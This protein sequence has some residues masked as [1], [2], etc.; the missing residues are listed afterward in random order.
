MTHWVEVDLSVSVTHLDRL[1]IWRPQDII[2]NE[3]FL[4]S[5]VPHL[6]PLLWFVQ[7]LRVDRTEKPGR[8]LKQRRRKQKKSCWLI[9]ILASTISPFLTV[10][11]LSFLERK[12]AVTLMGFGCDSLKLKNTSQG[13]KNL[14]GSK[15]SQL[16]ELYFMCLC[17]PWFSGGLLWSRLGWSLRR[18]NTRP[19]YVCSSFCS[20]YYL[21]I[22]TRECFDTEVYLVACRWRTLPSAHSFS[23]CRW[24]TLLPAHSFSGCRWRT[25][26]SAHS[27]SGCRWWILPSAHSFSGCRWFRCCRHFRGLPAIRE[28]QSVRRDVLVVFGPLGAG[29][30]AKI[31][32]DIIIHRYAAAN[33][34]GKSINATV[35]CNVQILSKPLGKC[36][37]SRINSWY[38]K[39]HQQH[40]SGAAGLVEDRLIYIQLVVLSYGFKINIEGCEM[41]KSNRK[42]YSPQMYIHCI[43]SVS[44][45]FFTV[46]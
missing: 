40:L 27:F 4:P 38:L 34:W 15:P 35:E 13:I 45:I 12:S 46:K 20:A 21:S 16:T 9:L 36:I 1:L 43:G 10:S 11:S 6:P 3:A 23:G 22:W 33:Q 25:L 31:T 39:W 18:K 26:P 30:V 37:I 8:W 24:R 28:L 17:I 32:A 29:N 5:V 42:S 2:G 14:W 19:C 41:I 44:G 7:Q